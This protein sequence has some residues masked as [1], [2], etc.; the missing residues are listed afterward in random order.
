MKKKAMSLLLAA[1]M[2][3]TLFA[4][5][6]SDNG[7]ASND[8]T[9][10]NDA[11]KES[12]EAGTSDN[13]GSTDG[14][15]LALV[16]DVGTIDD[17]SFNQGSWEGVQKYGDENGIAY[18]YYKSAEATTDSFQETIELAIEGGAKVIVCPG[19]LFEEPIYNMQTAHPDV[20]FILIDGEPHDAD[21]NYETADNT[22]AVLY[23]EDQAGFLAGYAAVKDGYT[24]LGFMGG[25]ALPAVIRYG[26]GYLAGADYAAKELGIDVDVTYTYTGSFDATP[27]AKSMATGWYQSGTEAIFACGGSVGNSVMAAAEESENG[28]V[29]GVDVDQSSESD[30]VIT[31][32]MKMLS[33]SVYTA[34]TEAYD[35][36]FAGGKT[37]TFDAANDGVGLPMD[38]SKFN[39][40]TQED[41]DTIYAKLVAGEITIDNDT[42]KEVTDLNLSNVTVNYVQ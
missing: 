6:G 2:T 18:K 25:M 10:G 4:G 30:T 31:S 34:I 35:G 13:A 32:S 5:C 7:A 21:N 38:T 36:T 41:Y 27:E 8:S 42:T 19:Y 28:K 26:Y 23:Q 14:Y 37:T 16:I 40:F 1:A 17:K 3:A 29:I 33:N 15:E 20:K 24:K 12:T 9:T 22:M 11:V 39:T